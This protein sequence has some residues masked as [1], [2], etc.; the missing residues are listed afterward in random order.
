MKK[1]MLVA[2]VAAIAGG[3]FAACEEDTA[4][5]YAYKMTLTGKST[6]PLAKKGNASKCVDAACFRKVGSYKVTGYVFGTTTDN[7]NPDE[8]I[9]GCACNDF[10]AIKSVLWNTG[11]KTLLT[12]ALEI[13]QLDLIGADAKSAEI[14]AT[15]GDLTLAGFGK[16]NTKT[17]KLTS[18]S[19]NFAGQVA[20]PKCSTCTYN[21]DTCDDTCE[22]TDSAVF[23]VCTLEA[24]TAETT[25][26]YGKWSLK[27]NAAAVKKLTKNYSEEGTVLI[28]SNV[29]VVQVP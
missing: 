14:V 3:A 9:E 8:C 24:T 6:V 28:P 22:E 15:L 10:S 18:A 16:Y 11:T 21:A 27:T 29:K 25:A 5:V 26:A 13:K 12:D 4:C 19:G 2:A 23:A 17:L 7:T 20:A 1:L